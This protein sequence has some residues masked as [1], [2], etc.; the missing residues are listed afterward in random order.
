MASVIAA[1]SAKAKA[2]TSIRTRTTEE[3]TAVINKVFGMV[4]MIV[5]IWASAHLL[6]WAVADKL[7]RI[8][9][10]ETS[11][12][13][14]SV[15]DRQLGCL[16]KNIYYEAGSEP[17]E[18][19]TAVAQVT[20]NRANSG[21]FPSDICQVIYQKN[22]FYEKVV[23]QYSWTCDRESGAR[24][25]NNANYNESMIVAKKVLLENYRLPSLK[26]AMYFHGKQIDPHWGKERV[27][28][29]GNHIFYK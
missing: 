18:G 25:I 3:I 13:T 29:I 5:G 8:E 4:F 11:Q 20:I 1:K 10:T 26:D 23:C 27:A 22:I 24:P 19:K 9:P 14:A 28:T 15:R 17:F 2:P 12:I 7:A 6:N 16:A 21:K